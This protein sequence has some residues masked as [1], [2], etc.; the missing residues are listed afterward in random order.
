MVFPKPSFM[1]LT[2]VPGGRVVNARKSE[3][4]KSAMNAFSFKADVSIITANMLIITSVDN[5]RVLMLRHSHVKQLPSFPVP[6]VVISFLH[7][8]FLSVP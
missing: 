1:V 3:T 8:I 5:N 7:L 6:G 4:R 2:I